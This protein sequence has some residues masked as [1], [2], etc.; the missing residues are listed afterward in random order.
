MN[1]FQNCTTRDQAKNLFRE[2]VKKLHP[3]TS[4][5]DSQKDFVLMYAQFEAFRPTAGRDEKEPFNASKF[6]NLVKKFDDLNNIKISFIGSFIW[7][8]DIV[9]GAMYQQKDK[10]KA[11]KIEG[12]NSA[13]WAKV[14]KSWYYSP[15]DYQQKART[16]TQTLEGLKNKFGCNSFKINERAQI[17]A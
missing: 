4:G 14:K 2:L 12:Y 8:E 16:K 5:Y 6:Y 1:Y 17:T 10:I 7:L 13:R 11:I 15:Q 3:D 9:P